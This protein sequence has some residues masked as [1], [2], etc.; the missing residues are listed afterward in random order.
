MTT[1]ALLGAAGKI[2]YRIGALLKDDPE[3]T[4]LHVEA[5]EKGI[6]R[7]AEA[8]IQTTPIDTAVKQADVVILAIPDILIGTVAAQIVPNLKPK[9]MVIGLDPA[10]PRSG[11]FPTREDISYFVT[12]PC[13]PPVYN[14]ETDPAARTDYFGG[15]AKQNIVCALMQGTDEQYALGE[16]IARKMFA[17]VMNAH[18]V[19]V[20]QMAILEPALVETIAIPCMMV[21]REALDEAVKRG[22]PFE[23]ARDFLLG[24]INIDIAILFGFLNAQFSDGAKLA[25]NRG[26][27]QLFKPDWKQ[28]FEPEAILHEVR[29]ITEGL[30]A[31]EKE[32]SRPGGTD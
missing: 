27:E 5:G 28:I 26:M 25:A 21:I 15:T 24:H 20:E 11:K 7:L 1:I 4:T 19:T 23:A 22:V 10:A 2:G 32:R 18:R 13:H 8:G 3:F 17:P 30:N 31:V 29:I 16:K 12:H 9:A 14:D 6:A